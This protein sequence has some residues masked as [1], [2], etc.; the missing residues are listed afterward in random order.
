MVIDR[1][2]DREQLSSGE[3]EKMETGETD[4]QNKAG[5]ACTGSPQ[6]HSL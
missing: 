4:G 5:V 3:D 1:V 2:R 6:T